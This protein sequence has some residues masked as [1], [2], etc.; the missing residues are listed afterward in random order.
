MYNLPF[1]K[2]NKNEPKP[3]HLTTAKGVITTAKV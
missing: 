2:Y 3:Y 1:L